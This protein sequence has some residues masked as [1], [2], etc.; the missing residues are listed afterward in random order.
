[1]DLKQDWR[2]GAHH[3]EEKLV[4]HD[5]H[6]N[7]GGWNACSGIGAGMV[8]SFNTLKQSRDFDSNGEYIKSWCPE[9]AEL[10]LKYIHT[11]WTVPEQER[12]Q[13]SGLLAYPAPIYVGKYTN[14]GGFQKLK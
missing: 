9:L 14:E 13:Y 2:F 3:F 10:P 11:P 8:R 12:T 6:S 4:D 1:M 7:Y 5:V